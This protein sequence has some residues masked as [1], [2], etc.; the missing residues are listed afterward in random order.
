MLRRM[1]PQWPPNRIARSSGQS[2]GWDS[3]KA[4]LLRQA[5]K[6]LPEDFLDRCRVEA[7]D[8]SAA[9]HERTGLQQ[10]RS[11]L[12]KMGRVRKAEPLGKT[13]AEADVKTFDLW[14]VPLEAV[15]EK[16]TADST[17]HWRKGLTVAAGM[18]GC[19]NMVSALLRQLN[20]R[21]PCIVEW[22]DMSS[23]FFRQHEIEEALG[24]LTKTSRRRCHATRRRPG[25]T[26]RQGWHPERRDY[27]PKIPLFLRY[28][29][30]SASD[31]RSP[32]W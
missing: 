8:L 32:N 19:K 13:F 24:V 4:A 20:F 14:C 1:R 18:A 11:R 6:N 9:S 10:A 31:D 21:S 12:K 27:I 23:R 2:T 17:R 3:V 16:P 7:P 26:C 22:E 15:A 25:T 5:I 30:S 29:R 28:G